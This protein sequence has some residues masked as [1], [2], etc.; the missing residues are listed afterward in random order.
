[1]HACLVYERDAIKMARLDEKDV[2]RRKRRNST[3]KGV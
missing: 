2:T 1:M 3:K